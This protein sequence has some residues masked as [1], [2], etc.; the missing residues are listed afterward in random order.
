MIAFIEG[1]VAEA[2]LDHI[3]VAA[4]GVGYY[5]NIPNNMVGSVSA[6]DHVRIHTCQIV[7]EDDISLFGFVDSEQK[8]VF[9]L[10]LQVSGIGPRVALNMIGAAEHGAIC[11]AIHN[12]DMIFLTRLPG[13]GKKTAQ[14]VILDLRD[15]VKN[16]PVI[17]H[18]S[19]SEKQALEASGLSNRTQTSNISIASMRDAVDALVVLG[20]TTR[21]AETTASDV[22]STLQD[23]ERKALTIDQYIRKCLQRLMQG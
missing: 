20:Y 16:M 7:R 17:Q 22:W 9:K 21:E 4:A 8:S 15:K 5:I 10:L 2:D 23:D 18:S 14:R 6:G 19:A 12:E 3:V 13:I 1:V 11:R